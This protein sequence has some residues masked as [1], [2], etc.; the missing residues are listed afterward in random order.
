MGF[1]TGTNQYTKL[2]TVTP[3]D[4]TV[5]ETTAG[6]YVGV[7]GSV[8]VETKKGGVVTLVGVPAG[9]LLAISVTK[10]RATGTTATDILAAYD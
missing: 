8:S 1:Q 2:V 6:L 3:S 7:G 4:S 5:L 9:S 10:V